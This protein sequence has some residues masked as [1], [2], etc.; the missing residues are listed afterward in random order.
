[1]IA[2]C[3][4]ALHQADVGVCTCLCDAHDT[5]FDGALRILRSAIRS[6]NNRVYALQK[7]QE[8]DYE[9]VTMIADDVQGRIAGVENALTRLQQDMGQ[10][11]E[12]IGAYSKGLPGIYLRLRGVEDEL[13]RVNERLSPFEK[14][15]ADLEGYEPVEPVEATLEVAEGTDVS[16]IMDILRRHEER[17][18]AV[19]ERLSPPEKQGRLADMTDAEYSKAVGSHA[20]EYDAGPAASP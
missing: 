8:K 15:R 3:D 13:K 16:Q 10:A 17:L 19:E 18:V 7:A 2:V 11:H 1:M 14:V 12:A 20:P 9:R 5:F 6:L 4:C